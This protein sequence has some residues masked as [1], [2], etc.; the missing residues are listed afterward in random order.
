MHRHRP[1]ALDV[2]LRSRALGAIPG[3]LGLHDEDK[4]TAAVL[5]RSRHSA[6]QPECLGTRLVPCLPVKELA[7]D[8]S[9][10]GDGQWK[11]YAGGYTDW[12][13]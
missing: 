1:V 3:F 4:D 2:D 5:R 12:L 7:A 10:E 13:R 9:A 8:L 11:E 6:A